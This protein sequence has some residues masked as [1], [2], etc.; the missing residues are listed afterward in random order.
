M[1]LSDFAMRS[2]SLRSSPESSNFVPLEDGLDAVRGGVRPVG[3]SQLRGESIRWQKV[4]ESVHREVPW[5]GVVVVVLG[6]RSEEPVV[7]VT[8]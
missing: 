7:G 6:V 3:L 5:L 4:E 1:S 8:T 2:S